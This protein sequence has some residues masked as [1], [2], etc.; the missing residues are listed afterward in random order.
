M[1]NIVE[2]RGA[3]EEDAYR[4]GNTWE[5]DPMYIV[6][7]GAPGLHEYLCTLRDVG[8]P[9]G[10]LARMRICH[11]FPFDGPVVLQDSEG[12]TR[13]V[14][15]RGMRHL[16]SRLDPGKAARIAIRDDS[17]ERA[18][19]IMQQLVYLRYPLA[20]ADVW[21]RGDERDARRAE[22]LR[23][24]GTTL[25]K[26]AGAVETTL[27]A[28]EGASINLS[29]E[30]K[31]ALAESCQQVLEACEGLAA[32]MDEAR[33][34]SVLF[35]VA[36]FPFSGRSTLASEITGTD[37]E[38]QPA[39]GAYLFR[40]AYEKANP[41]R[42]RTELAEDPAGWSR[43]SA[44][45]ALRH[46]GA[47]LYVLDASC[48]VSIED[49]R[50]IRDAA[51]LL[52]KG[53]R[54]PQ[55]FVVANMLDK[56][57][58]VRQ[59]QDPS[60]VAAL[61]RV[62][63]QLTELAGCEAFVLFGTSALECRCARQARDVAAKWPDRFGQLAAEGPGLADRL[64]AAVAEA[65]GMEEAQDLLRG[66]FFLR[67]RAQ[68]MR[69]LLDWED[70]LEAAEEQSGVPYLLSFLAHGLAERAARS[71]PEGTAERLA[72]RLA[73]FSAAQERISSLAGRAG[74]VPAEQ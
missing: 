15:L 3:M 7:S 6:A 49:A 47:T 61:D 14:P 12:A 37:V 16:A 54:F 34:V 35:A 62:R 51:R 1:E 33:R 13:M 50:R 68:Y 67:E 46:S 48:P 44:R 23:A 19:R 70:T 21:L 25:Q 58:G 31:A 53:R 38:A 22:Q 20:K 26:A 60:P 45:G 66:L 56:A 72:V 29:E 63:A 41:S 39:D 11:D 17:Q 36:G 30:E 55:L 10:I 42:M 9:A 8:V 32:D 64:D 71:M 28:L 65:K 24:A 27:R 69:D 43:K 52:Q 4:I 57:V 2:L 5:H 73:T 18:A 74:A 40:L 59:D